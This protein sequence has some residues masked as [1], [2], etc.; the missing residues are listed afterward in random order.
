ML[1]GCTFKYIVQKMNGQ[2]APSVGTVSMACHDFK[3]DENYRIIWPFIQRK[4]P[5]ALAEKLIE[6][7]VLKDED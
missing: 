7:D 2:L 1:Y 3:L 5:V 4:D 6:L